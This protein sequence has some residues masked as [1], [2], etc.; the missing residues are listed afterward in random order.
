MKLSEDDIRFYVIDTGIGVSEA[1][2]TII[3]KPFGRLKQ[4]LPEATEEMDSD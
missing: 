4:D 3:F 2:R 1:D